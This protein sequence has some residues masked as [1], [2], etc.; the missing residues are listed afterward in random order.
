MVRVDFKVNEIKELFCGC[1]DMDFFGKV[2]KK[3]IP[4]KTQKSK[5]AKPDRL[6]K[7]F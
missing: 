3:V 4:Q 6:A 2:K 1:K 7:T 5:A